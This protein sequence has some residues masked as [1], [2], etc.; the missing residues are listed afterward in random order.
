MKTSKDG[1]VIGQ[2]LAGA[3]ITV[4]RGK[5]DIN[6]NWTYQVFYAPRK[7]KISIQHAAAC[8]RRLPISDLSEFVNL[9]YAAKEVAE[10]VVAYINT[11]VI[12]H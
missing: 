9:D 3:D 6:G 11:Y 2:T 1:I 4:H 10:D 8:T 12:K 7:R 5:H